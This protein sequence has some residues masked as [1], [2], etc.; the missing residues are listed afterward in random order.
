MIYY[1]ICPDID[2]CAEEIDN[3]IHSFIHVQ[4]LLEASFVDVM[5]DDGITCNGM[6][7]LYIAFN[8]I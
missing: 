4:T 6:Q 7:K 5:D 3:C 2:E 8:H 1:T